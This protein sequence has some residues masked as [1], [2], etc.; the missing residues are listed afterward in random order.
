MAFILVVRRWKSKLFVG[1]SSVKKKGLYKKVRYLLTLFFLDRPI[2]YFTLS[3]DNQFYLSR[4]ILFVGKGPLGLS[5]RLSSL[6]NPFIPRL[7]N[8]LFYYSRESSPWPSLW[9]RIKDERQSVIDL[10]T[11]YPYSMNLLSY[12]AFVRIHASKQSMRLMSLIECKPSSLRSNFHFNVSKVWNSNLQIC[13]AFDLT[14]IL[15]IY[16][17]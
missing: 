4:K 3:N 7:A 8:L 6:V 16:M 9:E 12:S 11:Y 10:S 5:A 13:F 17:F 14:V 2:Y 15:F 1:N